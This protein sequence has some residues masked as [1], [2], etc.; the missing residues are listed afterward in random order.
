[1]KKW[2][3]F[4]IIFV[5]LATMGF[6]SKYSINF[7]LDY[8]LGVSDYFDTYTTFYSYDGKNFRETSDNRM[9]FGFSITA[10]IPVMNRLYVVPGFSLKFGHQNYE[11][12]EIPAETGDED[13]DVATYF[14]TILS[15]RVSLLY[16]VLRFTSNWNVNALLGLNINS[17][18]GDQGMR[19]E[20]DTYLSV[21]AGLGAT[22][23]ELKHFG[24]QILG[25]YEFPF[26][27]DK[28][29]FLGIQIGINYR[30]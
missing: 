22:F 11:Y 4:L 16:D 7:N 26:S 19:E 9:G 29:T 1:M 27:G 12:Q 18:S 17:F 6:S 14:F 25:Y 5:S 13:A 3:G 15:G 21:R 30:F 10:T 23:F 28:F 24:F 2:A 8:N 20:D